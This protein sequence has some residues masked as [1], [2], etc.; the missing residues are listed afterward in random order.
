MK[1]TTR[2][3]REPSAHPRPARFAR[4]GRPPKFGRP[5]QLVAMTLPE[6]VLNSL[7]T[8]HQDPAWAIVQLVESR[9]RNRTTERQSTAASTTAELV[10]LPGKRG[11]IVV[12]DNVFGRIP[13]ISMIPLADGRSFLAF[14]E[15]ARLADLEVAIID[16][17]ALIPSS[18]VEHARLTRILETVRGWRRDRR[19][20]FRSKSII[21]VEA[22][23]RIAQT[24]LMSR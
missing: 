12:Q 24:S 21:V 5:S 15:P 20:V 6:D 2:S 22:S 18:T 8:I 23:D 9:L 13:G 11:L 17:L 7:R 4:R 3:R 10:H 19:L 16:K 1:R 14:D